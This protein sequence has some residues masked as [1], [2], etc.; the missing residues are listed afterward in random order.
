MKKETIYE[1]KSLYRD[2]F[3]VTG[4]RFGEGKKAACIVGSSRGNEIQQLYVCS[5]IVRA[6]K[7]L[8]RDGCIQEEN[9]IL[10]VPSMNPYSMNIQKRFWQTDN[11]DI[12]RMFPGYD[13]GETTQRIAG[14][15]FEVIQDYAYGM[16]FT[17]FYMPGNFIPH[18][19]VMKTGMEDVELAKQFGLPYVVKRRVR[20]YDTTTLNY[21]WQLWE[22]KA[23]SIYTSS[24][25]NIDRESAR[26]AVR[27]VL[28]FL[29]LQ[30]I[31]SYHTHAGYASE[32][33]EDVDMVSVRTR[34]A[35]LFECEVRIFQE[36][37]SGQVLARVLD[38]YEGTVLEEIVS[39]ADG[40]VFFAHNEPLTYSHTAVFKLIRSGRI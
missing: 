26:Q 36:V 5:Q 2:D 33:V 27:G 3:R 28:N 30:G 7:E 10:V 29:Y 25:N 24:T 12:N 19:R 35:G 34:S 9:E 18:V 39:P 17:S 20:P 8:E 40:I 14:G 21:N 22:S 13:E 4:Y 6:L 16:Q 31:I 37:L 38:P 32:V 23:F 1:I 11:T 15:V